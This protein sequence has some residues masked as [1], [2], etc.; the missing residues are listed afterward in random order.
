[1]NYV[2]EAWYVASWVH[3]HDPTK[4]L[5]VSI[6]GEPIVIW[7]SNGRLVAFAD[8]CIH[9]MAPL[10][11]GRC[12]NGA[13]R[14]MYHGL[15]Y[16]TNGIVVEIPGG[17]KTPPKAQVRSYPIVERDSWIWVWMGDP[18]RADESLIPPVIGLENPDWI[19][20][21][22]HLDY[23]AEA[24]LIN[25]NLLDFS[26]L[27]YVHAN[28]FGAGSEFAE[29]LP[30]LTML[31]RG[32]RYT[33]W[34]VETSNPVGGG[35]EGVRVDAYMSYDFVVPGIL[36]MW[37]GLFPSGTARSYQFGKPDYDAAVGGV[38]FTSQ[39]VTPTC[40]QGAR[41]F[42][43]VGPN[44]KQGDSRLR[45]AHLEIA[46]KAFEEDRIMIEAQQRVINLSSERTTMLTA[47]DKAITMYN[48]LLKKLAREA[49]IA[50]SQLSQA[51]SLI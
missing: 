12:E 20:G 9:R 13:L 48:G 43:S 45:D 40:E 19:L 4:P 29:E 26:H 6:L 37:N 22:G 10:S 32:V 7:R 31:P 38:S 50:K 36:T 18:S 34:T 1:M 33:R 44:A 30:Q 8:R 14:C 11:L 16:D 51:Q 35:E 25:E 39:A 24:S 46:L 15:L 27:T 5:A 21:A 17:A 47:H 23:R 2:R 41:Y 28:S 49:G 3:E 42:F